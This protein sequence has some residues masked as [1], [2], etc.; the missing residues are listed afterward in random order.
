MENNL[1]S[2][3]NKLI[4]ANN[5]CFN[6]KYLENKKNKQKFIVQKT[7]NLKKLIH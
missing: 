1:I 7:M 4:T 5:D 6:K 3:Q 2:M